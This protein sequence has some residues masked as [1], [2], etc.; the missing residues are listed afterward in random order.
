MSW[1]L[2][3]IEQT[4]ANGTTTTTT[5]VPGSGT[6]SRTDSGRE[7]TEVSNDT[8]ASNGLRVSSNVIDADGVQTQK[9]HYAMALRLKIPVHNRQPIPSA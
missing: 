7:D 4:S 9:S 3:H 8:V 2:E 5:D 1:L 6:E